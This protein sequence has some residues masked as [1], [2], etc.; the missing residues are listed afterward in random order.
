MKLF[1][2]M[3]FA[4]VVVAGCSKN[5]AVNPQNGKG[6]NT[7]G[8][9]PSKPDTTIK[10][11]HD[12]SIHLATFKINPQVVKTSVS[13]TN[14]ILK[15]NENIDLLF[16]AEGYQK[17]SSVHLIENFKNT[18]LTGFDFTTLAEGGNTTLNWVDDNLNNV[19]LKTVSDTLVN[20]V[21]MVKINVHRPFTFF[22]V[23][24]TNQAALGQQA[25]FVQRK[26]DTVSFKSYSYYNQKN[27]LTTQ[28][29]AR[30]VYTK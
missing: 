9:T 17:T 22:R 18:M 25:M 11:S 13:G 8:G 1:I 6:T 4:A 7:G 12:D 3:L 29:S 5:G 23:Y 10:L 30:L 20:K 14:L 24:S 27:Y 19:I 2:T 26:T 21:K 16:T 28:S 15:F